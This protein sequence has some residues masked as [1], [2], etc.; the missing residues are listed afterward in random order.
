M[1]S[2]KKSRRKKFLLPRCNNKGPVDT[3]IQE[4]IDEYDILEDI[5]IES[6]STVD[7]VGSRYMSAT[8]VTMDTLGH[9]T[10]SHHIGGPSAHVNLDNYSLPY[11]LFNLIISD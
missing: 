5:T 2:R 3:V 4:I 6:A 10:K 9:N 8:V 7:S 11:N 1:T